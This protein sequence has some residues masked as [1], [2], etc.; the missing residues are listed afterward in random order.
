MSRFVDERVVEMSFD[1]K[2]FEKNVKTSMGTID[3][4]KSSLDFSGTSNAIS[5]ELGSINVSGLTAAMY[6][7]KQQFTALEVVAITALANITNRIVNLGVE[8]VKSLSTDNIAAGWQKLGQIA[9]SEATL[10]AQGFEQDKVTETLEKLTWFADETS[11]SLTDMVDNMS[12]FTA[13]GRDLDESANAMMGIANWA[14]LAGQNSTKASTAMYQLSQALGRGYVGWA[15]YKSIV[16]ANMDMREFRQRALDMAVLKGELVA[17]TDGSYASKNGDIFNIDNFTESLSTGQWF[18]SDVLLATLN[19]YAEGANKIFQLI[20]DDDSVD[21][22]TEAIKKYSD[23]IDAFQLK[24]FLAAQEA[25]TF[26]DTIL[27]VQDAVSSGYMMMFTKVFGAVSEAKVFWTDLAN[28]LYNVFMDGMWKKIDI[29]DIWANLDGRDDLF[30]NTEENTGAFWNLF[31]AIVAIKDLISGAWQDVFGFSEA[32]EYGK[33]I[34]EIAV[35]LKDLT[36]RF[37]EFTSKLF[38]NKEATKDLK[39]I[40]RGLFSIL[41]IVGKTFKA[42]YKGLKPVYEVLSQI[43]GNLNL[44]GFFGDIGNAIAN[45]ADSDDMFESITESISGFLKTIINFI[46]KSEIIETVMTGA[47]IAVSWLGDKLNTVVIPTVKKTG[48]LLGWL[49]KEITI[50]LDKT[51]ALIAKFI[52]WFKTNERIQNG[53]AKFKSLMVTIGE[54]FSYARDKIVEFFKSFNKGDSDGFLEFSED[55]EKRLKPFAK[56]VEG[57]VT[58]LEGLWTVIKSVSNTVGQFFKFIGESLTKIGNKLK[59]IF[60]KE[61]GDVDFAKLFTVGFWGAI[62]VGVYRFAEVLQSIT[63]VIR[64]AFEGMFDY[65]NSKAMQQYMEAI[66]TMSISI[67][68]MVASLI[69]L[70]SIDE[71]VLKRGLASLTALIAYIVGTMILMKNLVKGSSTKSIIKDGRK[72]I[73][74]TIDMTSN[75]VGLGV[76]FMGLGVAVMLLATSMKLINTMDPKEL[77]YGL[78][79][80]GSLMGMLTV[81]MRLVSSKDKQV[82]KAVKSMVKMALSIALLVRPLKRIGGIDTKVAIKGLIGI[83]SLMIIVTGYSRYSKVMNKSQKAVYGLIG[84]AVALNLMILPLTLIGMMDILKIG[85]TLLSLGV[86]FGL[87]TAASKSLKLKD[88][89]RLKV[90][91]KE[92]IKLSIALSFFGTSMLIVG[93]NSWN[94][95]AKSIVSISGIFIAMA[96]LGKSLTKPRVANLSKL[97]WML[98]PLSIGLLAFGASLVGISLIPWKNIGKSMLLVIGILSMLTILTKVL[99]SVGS[100]PKSLLILGVALGVL[101]GGLLLFSVALIALGNIPF[102]VIATGLLGIM[103][104][105]G[106]LV[107]VGYLITPI[108]PSLLALATTMLIMAGAVAIFG[109]GAVLL[110][111]AFAIFTAAVVAGG[112]A[113]GVTLGL[114]ASAVLAAMPT[115]IAAIGEF[116][117]GLIQKWIEVIPLV[118]TSFKVFIVEFVKALGELIPEIGA[119]IVTLGKELLNIIDELAPTITNTMLNLMTSILDGLIKHAPDLATK[120]LDLYIGIFNS[121]QTKIP[122]IMESMRLFITEIIIAAVDEITAFYPMLVDE[123][124]R[125]I[126]GLLDGLGLAIEENSS[127]IN[128]AMKRFGNHILQAFKNFFGINS[129]STVMASLGGFLVQGLI[130]GLWDN[131]VY[132]LQSIGTWVRNIWNTLVTKFLEAIDMGKTLVLNIKDGAASAWGTIKEWFSEKATSIVDV[133]S[134]IKGFIKNAGRDVLGNFKE[135]FKNAWN[136]ALGIA[137]WIGEKVDW[138]KDTFRN[139]P[140]SFRNIGGNIMDGLKEGLRD[141]WHKVK[142]VLNT[143]VGYL[144]LWAQDLLGIA[145]PSKVFKEI[146]GYVSEGMAVGID[147][148]TKMVKKSALDMADGAIDS[149][150]KSG[151]NNALSSILDMLSG[152]FDNEIVIKPVLDLSEIQNGKNLMSS[153]LSGNYGIDVSNS[154]ANVVRDNINKPADKNNKTNTTSSGENNGAEIINN[155]FN[156]TGANPKEIAEE[157]SKVLQNQVDR[158]KLRWGV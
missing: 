26:R 75:L 38:L 16:N 86:L 67:M 20:A 45:F 123:G 6:R 60:T 106:I 93:L 104:L 145:S 147:S 70:G 55:A 46:E 41:K 141:T 62:A 129:P 13:S 87:V 140:E 23:E 44:L 21:T 84:I 138:I 88:A 48:L 146:G 32:E 91:A 136:G 25:R 126:I 9:I 39:N 53:F 10:L 5:N 78:L 144:P 83:A 37:K 52:N 14:A 120:L 24:A 158:R 97:I 111:K 101:S 98:I 155:T 34:N 150:E 72:S 50:L 18:T 31:N 42:V 85:K 151:M 149:V 112:V 43:T 157:V 35:K 113:F 119:V 71:G 33:Q 122:E 66:K 74:D 19:E 29:L 139:L 15:D 103:A 132:L 128:E 127:K 59:E 143:L 47:T 54:S 1:N 81:V 109:V 133:F 7:A 51:G 2:K 117:K 96:Y 69:I 82:N 156:I 79:I 49:G 63:S 57:F 131:L 90:L 107:G 130:K 73:K 148:N 61:N 153:M 56:F 40:F 124:F 152:E 118:I 22:A 27:A 114:M 115:I 76:A 125:L 4:L 11:Y 58:L 100:G 135:G 8:M 134:N 65:F 121:L 99:K 94:T 80:V 68:L 142:E 116:V 89:N 102:K 92:L 77:A 110:A 105:F 137:R 64:D 30:A 3:K 28:E 95:I 36:T 154:M 108:I 12:K 17:L